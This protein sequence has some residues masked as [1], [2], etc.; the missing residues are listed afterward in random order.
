MTTEKQPAERDQDRLLWYALGGVVAGYTLMRLYLMW[1]E[2]RRQQHDDEDGG[3][4]D[5]G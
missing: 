2:R 3:C 4:R 1:Q 5:C